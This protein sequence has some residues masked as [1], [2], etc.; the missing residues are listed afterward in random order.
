MINDL[1]SKHVISD[2]ENMTKDWKMNHT[3]GVT[4]LQS[5]IVC[6][7]IVSSYPQPYPRTGC[8]FWKFL[9]AFFLLFFF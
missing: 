5:S 9:Q 4:M 2:E 7:A 1:V 3:N 6:V 8:S